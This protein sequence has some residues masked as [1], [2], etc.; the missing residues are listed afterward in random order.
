MRKKDPH[1]ASRLA[2]L[3]PLPAP[4]AEMLKLGNQLCFPLYAAARLMVQAYRPLLDEIGLT[5]PQYLTMMALWEEDG[6]SVKEIGTRLFLDS[7]TLT[8]LLQKLEEM[9]LVERARARHDDRT[10][11]NRLTPR[12]KAL[13]DRAALV[14]WALF[15]QSGMTPEE[16]EATR[17]DIKRLLE[18]LVT[19]SAGA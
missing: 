10:V 12:G 17:A 11:L 19:G 8:P 5:Y 16:F 14:P 6:L 3:P 18:R 4:A 9:N 2:A 1:E 15:C 13:K 7:G